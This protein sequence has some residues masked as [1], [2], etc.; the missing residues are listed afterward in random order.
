MGADLYDSESEET[1]VGELEETPGEELFA[2]STHA[3]QASC[4]ASRSTLLRL[5]V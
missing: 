1:D 4:N 2:T 5:R 3:S